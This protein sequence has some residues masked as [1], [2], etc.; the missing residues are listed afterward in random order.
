MLR[1]D[2]LKKSRIFAKP[3]ETEPDSVAKPPEV[4]KKTY[5]RRFMMLI[6]GGALI[7]IGLVMFTV[8]FF[9]QNMVFG[10]PSIFLIGGGVILFKYY[11]GKT[12]DAVIQHIGEVNKAQVNSL[13]LY[14]NKI[15]F[16]NVN[17]PE[18]YPQQC[19]NDKKHYYVQKWDEATKRLVSFVLPDQQYYDPGVFAER[20]LELPAHQKIF[21]RKPNL[22][23]KIKT[24]LLVLAIGIVWL[25][26]LTTTG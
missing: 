26:I 25:L 15:A 10:G 17:D 16:E 9:T 18:G 5:T 19:L 11:W 24:G 23:Q 1:G 21:T 2:I 22:F 7:G 8:Y 13:C 20:V 14:P 12:D 4:I 3:I 6:M